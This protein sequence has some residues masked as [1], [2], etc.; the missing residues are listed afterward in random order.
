VQSLQ[1]KAKHPLL[2]ISSAAYAQPIRVHGR[3]EIHATSLNLF[4]IRRGRRQTAGGGAEPPKGMQAQAQRM[5][6][7]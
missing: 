6:D 4:T 3:H 2:G 5:W 7:T 1:R